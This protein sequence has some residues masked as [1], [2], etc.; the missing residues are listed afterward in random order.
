MKLKYK[1]HFNIHLLLFYLYLIGKIG[2]SSNFRSPRSQASG[3]A[4]TLH[5]S[6]SKQH[7]RAQ[8]QKTVCWPCRLRC[9]TNGRSSSTTYRIS[10]AV[11]A[12]PTWYTY[13]PYTCYRTIFPRKALVDTGRYHYSDTLVSTFTLI[14]VLNIRPVDSALKIFY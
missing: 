6:Y 13:L 5:R 11:C 9:V 1:C 10:Q 7:N 14:T 4:H 2:L 3:H 12:I 8:V